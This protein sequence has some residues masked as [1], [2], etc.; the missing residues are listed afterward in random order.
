EKQQLEFKF[1]SNSDL[2]K[3]RSQYR[4]LAAKLTNI[5][6]Q[7]RTDVGPGHRDATTLREQMDGLRALIREEQQRIVDSYASE[8]QVAKARES[9]IIA[10]MAQSVGEAEKSSPALVAMRELESSADTLRDL[11]NSFLQ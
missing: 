4:E 6:S 7:Y 5:E 11:Y 3:L 2:V 8:L 9:G 10:G 1:A